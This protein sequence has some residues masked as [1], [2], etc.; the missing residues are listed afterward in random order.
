MQILWK[1][2]S[3]IVVFHFLKGSLVCLCLKYWIMKFKMWSNNYRNLKNILPF[4]DLLIR[5][6]PLYL[7]DVT[8]WPDSSKPNICLMSHSELELSDSE[9]DY[10]SICIFFKISNPLFFRKFSCC[11]NDQAYQFPQ[12]FRE[13]PF[14]LLLPSSS[15]HYTDWVSLSIVVLF[16]LF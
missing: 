3:I 10:F 9:N 2:T 5:L 14:A 7:R 13:T 8:L 12:N 16:G 6:V 1:V 4:C 11:L 15:S